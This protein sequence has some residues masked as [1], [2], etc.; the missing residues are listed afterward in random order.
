MLSMSITVA[1]PPSWSKRKQADALAGTVRPTGQ[2]GF[3][4]HLRN[5]LPTPSTTIVWADDSSDCRH[6]DV[7][8]LRHGAGCGA[9]GAGGMIS[10]YTAALMI[11]ASSALAGAPLVPERAPDA[12]RLAPS[13][14]AARDAV[15]A[16]LH[17]ARPQRAGGDEAAR[18]PRLRDRPGE[19]GNYEVDHLVSSS[20]TARTASR[21]CGR[22][23]TP[24]RSVRTSSTLGATAPERRARGRAKAAGVQ[25][26]AAARD[27][28]ARLSRTTG[29]RLIGAPFHLLTPPGRVGVR[30]Q[31]G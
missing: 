16:R 29:P 18:V 25:R 28:A 5:W 15:Q 7:Q 6:A 26:Q 2:T 11:L 31:P 12:R 20:S 1:I 27:G 22:R 3:G 14:H 8:A 17:G 9:R 13:S 10:T 24:E 23:A 4:Q 19:R 21:T 30:N